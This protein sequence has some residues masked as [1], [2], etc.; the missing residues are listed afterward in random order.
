MSI[1]EVDGLS[2]A[3]LK[4]L[5]QLPT[6][7]S[8]L[9]RLKLVAGNFP[10]GFQAEAI[11][12][13][14]LI[15]VFKSAVQT[16]VANLAD[17]AYPTLAEALTH[18]AD[19][20]KGTLVL[21]TNDGANNGLYLSDGATL[22]KTEYDTIVLSD[23]FSDIETIMD[24]VN[25]AANTKAVS[26]LGRDYWT[27]ATLD[28][29]IADGLLKI[30]DLEAAIEIAAA[31]GAGANG[32]TDLLIATQAGRTQRAKNLEYA[33]IK[34]FTG[35][36]DSV[37]LYNALN[38]NGLIEVREPLSAVYTDSSQAINVL[39][40][41]ENL[42]VNS[43]TTITLPASTLTFNSDY[44]A[45][46]TQDHALL[47][48]KGAEPVAATINSVVSAVGGDGS[49]DVTYQFADASNINVGDFLK[50]DK[51]ACGAAWFERTPI[52]K[53]YLGE[54]SVGINKM[55]VGSTSGNT[56]I[57]GG[58]TADSIPSN[59]L[60]VG[61]LIH[62]K[63]Q[64]REVSAV[65]DTLRT[66]TVNTAFESGSAEDEFDTDSL[67]YQWWYHTKPNAGTISVVGQTITG[68]GTNFLSVVDEGDIVLFNGCMVQ[69][70]TVDSDTQLT[71]N[72]IA[73]HNS[74]NTKYSIIKSGLIAHEGTWQVTAKTGNNVTVSLKC[75]NGYHATTNTVAPYFKGFAPTVKGW[76]GADVKVMKTILKQTKSGGHG[77][78][79]EQGGHVKLL[80][81]LVIA[82]TTSGTGLL[83]KGIGG[84]YDAIQSRL[85][86]GDS[87]A[88]S[89]FANSV[90]GF[91]GSH[92][93]AP[94][95]H[96]IGS[97]SNSVY[98][99]DGGAGYLRGA[100]IAG[101][102]GIGVLIS[103]NYIR[104]STC[105]II[106]CKAQGLRT[107]AGGFFYSDSGFIY[108]NVSHGVMAVN[109][110]GG[111]FVD[112]F[113][114]CN[115]GNG[116]NTQNCGTGRYTRNLAACNK[117]HGMSFTASVVEAGQCW[118]TGSGSGALG[119]RSGVVANN[120]Q[121]G[122]FAGTASGNP[123]AGILALDGARVAARMSYSSKNG[124]SG[125]SCQFLSQVIGTGG[126]ADG[127]YGTSNV[128]T[129]NSGTVLG[130]GA[131]L[132]QQLLGSLYTGVTTLTNGGV[133]T[134]TKNPALAYV[135][136]EIEIYNAS[137]SG[138]KGKA[139][140]RTG[141]SPNTSKISGHANFSVTTGVLDGSNGTAGNLILS[142]HTDGKIYIANQTGS[143]MTISYLIKG[144]V[145]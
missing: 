19:L 144:N 125:V 39:S 27:L 118:A 101:A 77:F 80:D 33:T 29:L 72:I 17:I 61:D 41:L 42:I 3:D 79:G 48:I 90:F 69:V 83:L 65:N 116:I 132:S 137:L 92:I 127:N 139:E 70:K 43:P 63:G 88:I 100:V 104:L 94:S 47:T 91:N 110:S 93:H 55:G 143:A 18:M 126:Y 46:Y 31:A 15:E 102:G 112:G 20:P 105:R 60:D 36:D 25:G 9:G 76:I 130:F 119:G 95:A 45:K 22:N 7:K 78:V 21:I 123:S 44:I 99:I 113:T 117:S 56:L 50:I 86:L 68:V 108:G 136:G 24:V 96:F 142:T 32:W 28:A 81:N 35:A 10:S 134:I 111:Q 106:G 87:V 62:F 140:F 124:Q 73:F 109:I 122:L 98:L 34:D 58:T 6:I 97:A 120:T 129:A 133:I 1:V 49:W 115:G 135:F 84:A 38:S 82:G 52:R 74:L 145:L 30:E 57:L 107:D 53:A 11:T 103:G 59:W 128:V 13:N 37:R 89:G 5:S 2:A 141:T 67:R 8:I 4:T 12:V 75:W 54:L 23:V 71:I 131:S 121:L 51:V 114:M 138:V 16:P 64:T 26:R 14:Q 66:V 40:K 85:V